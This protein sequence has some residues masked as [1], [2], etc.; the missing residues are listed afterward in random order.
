MINTYTQVL[1]SLSHDSIPKKAIKPI[2]K[3]EEL[4]ECVIVF[5]NIFHVQTYKTQKH[6]Y[7]VYF[8]YVSS[9]NLL[10]HTC[11]HSCS[12]SLHCKLPS[13]LSSKGKQTGKTVQTDFWAD[14]FVSYMISSLKFEIS[15]TSG[16]SVG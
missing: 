12:P 4:R 11:S 10:F 6:V 8:L 14:N 5:I 16:F 9:A 7:G 15:V 2:S 1:T 3:W 13:L